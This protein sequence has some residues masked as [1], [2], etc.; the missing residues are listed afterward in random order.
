MSN[1]HTGSVVASLCTCPEPTQALVP[2]R[3][4]ANSRQTAVFQTQ[5]VLL[6]N[7]APVRQLRGANDLAGKPTL[8][9]SRLI[10]TVGQ[11]SLIQFHRDCPGRQVRPD[12]SRPIWAISPNGAD[13]ALAGR[14]KSSST[15]R[16]LHIWIS[17]AYQSN[18]EIPNF[19]SCIPLDKTLYVILAL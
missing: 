14:L 5:W 15:E 13:L 18:S 1:P 9:Q 10:S 17:P 19:P 7:D 2:T 6:L 3:C 4:A 12:A 11:Q 16:T 8:G